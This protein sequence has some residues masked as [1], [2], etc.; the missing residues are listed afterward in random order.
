MR[1][2][3]R[4]LLMQDTM[5]RIMNDFAARS[6]AA[7][8]LNYDGGTVRFEVTQCTMSFGQIY[9]FI[10]GL[11]ERRHINDYSCKLS[12]LEEVFNAHATESM[13]MALNARLERRRTSAAFSSV[14][15]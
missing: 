12:S 5:A 1:N 9:A 2:V 11:R 4:E 10:E 15:E 14:Q 6:M 7:R 8:V 3:L 13:Y